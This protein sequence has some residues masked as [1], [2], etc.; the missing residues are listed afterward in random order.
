[1]RQTDGGEYTLWTM[2]ADGS[3][4]VALTPAGVS[5]RHPSW[6]P[7]GLKIVFDRASATSGRDLW[8]IDG[9]GSGL[10]SIVTHAGSDSE[11]A[12]SPDGTHIAFTT[13]R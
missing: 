8:V 10:R 9:T 1:M 2:G 11:P 4:A 7:D 5:A 3:G 12:W 13:D 6:S